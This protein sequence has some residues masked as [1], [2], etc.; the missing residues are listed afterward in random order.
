MLLTIAIIFDEIFKNIPPIIRES[1]KSPLGL[2]SLAIIAISL[3][4][5]FV[6]FVTRTLAKRHQSRGLN[7]AAFSLFIGVV[8]FALSIIYEIAPKNIPDQ[9]SSN[10]CLKILQDAE[11]VASPAL[12]INLDEIESADFQKITA[13]L[14]DAISLLNKKSDSSCAIVVNQVK[15][16]Y[17]DR[18]N[19]ID[20]IKL[21]K[22]SP[23]INPTEKP[24]SSINKRQ[25]DEI[26]LNAI[27]AVSRANEA[28]TKNDLIDARNLLESS[29]TR[30]KNLE[31]VNNYKM[32]VSQRLKKYNFVLGQIDEFISELNKP[33]TPTELQNSCYIRL[34]GDCK[35]PSFSPL[36]D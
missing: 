21:S 4:V 6:A 36:I 10:V 30:L 25:I 13:S 19:L 24:E 35:L 9:S 3:I 29:I 23:P 34:F 16:R 15:G 33:K 28:W 14:D 11:K 17:Q 12:N 31:V 26:H 32:L 27:D 5:F 22:S 2:A 8:L 1:S 7:F 20:Y 18:K